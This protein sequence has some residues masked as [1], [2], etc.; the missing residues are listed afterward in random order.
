MHQRRALLIVGLLA[1]VSLGAYWL[2]RPRAVLVETA[3]VS[4]ERFEAIVEEDGHT[5]VRDRYVLS[6]PL[7]G[8]VPRSSLHAGDTVKEG[9][10]LTTIAP[11]I[12]PLLDIRLRQELEARVGSAEATLEET[13]ALEERARVLLA[14]AR[15]DFERTTQLKEREVASATQLERDL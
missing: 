12:S 4:E 15:S 10:T 7:A 6:A 3:T 9:Q 5:R 1:L 11:N 2:V 14:R 13:A 8:R